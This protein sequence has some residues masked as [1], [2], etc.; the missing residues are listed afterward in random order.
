ML[1]RAPA[2]LVL[3]LLAVGFFGSSGI[4]LL[5]TVQERAEHEGV[6]AGVVADQS[7]VLRPLAMTGVDT[8]LALFASQAEALLA[9]NAMP[10]RRR[11]QH[12]GGRWSGR[13][14]AGDQ[15]P[16][17]LP[18]RLPEHAPLLREP[19]DDDQTAASVRARRPR[20]QHRLLRRGVVDLDP[21]DAR[22]VPLVQV[23][24]RWE[25]TV[26]VDVRHQFGDHQQ[27][28]DRIVVVQI[29]QS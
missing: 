26:V 25:T 3:D 13:T 24:P 20:P 12:A 14:R 11:G 28:V 22:S 6:P 17:G 4:N 29:P 18:E 5:L 9:L 7:A 1:E 23:K 19:V 8:R 21:D 2:G 16:D 27:H 15:C 10:A